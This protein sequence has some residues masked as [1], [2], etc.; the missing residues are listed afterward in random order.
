MAIGRVPR[1]RDLLDAGFGF[2]TIY[3]GDIEPDFAGGAQYGIR[4]AY[5]KP[6]QT[7]PGPSDWGAIGAWAWGL[8]RAMDYLE[9]DP[10][11]D[12]KRI[13]IP[14]ISRLGKTVLWAGAKD[15]RFAMVIAS[16]S[17]EGGAALSRRNYGETVKNLNIN[18]GYHSQAITRNSVT[19]WMSC[20]WIRI[21]FFRSLPRGLCF[22]RREIRIS[23]LTREESSSPRLRLVPCGSCLER[24]I[25]EQRRCRLREARFC[26]RSHTR[27]TP[28]GMAQY[29]P[30]GMCSSS[31]CGGA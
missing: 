17:G 2:A 12:S 28:A 25:S 16:C 11:V 5:L 15:T 21:C 9:T 23:G 6:G 20:R 30:I 3:Y 7:E 1:V 27:C 19:T 31:S 26:I 8:S 18:F 10:G 14:G 4:G 13:A 24:T 29:L 22:C